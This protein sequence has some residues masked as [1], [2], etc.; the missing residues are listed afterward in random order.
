MTLRPTTR[1]GL[2]ALGLGLTA[3]GIAALPLAATT[4]AGA[5]GASFSF[6]FIG[7][8]P[9]KAVQQGQMPALTADVNADPDVAFVAHS[10]DFKG[11][12]DSCSD[13]N[14][15][16]T[17][18]LFSAF[19]TPFWYTIGDND[20]T[21]C[22]RANNGGFHPLERLAKVRSLYF[23]TPTQTTDF[24]VP[25]HP[26]LAVHPQ[27]AVPGSDNATYVDNNWFQKDC[28][29]FGSVH[30][31]TSNNGLPNKLV[32]NGS[33]DTTDLA[34]Y[35]Y[36]A[37]PAITIAPPLSGY[38]EA[39]SFPAETDA[40]KQEALA[41]IAADV[42]W[43]DAIFDAAIAN[44]SE[45]VFI[46]TQAEP[47]VQATPDNDKTFGD[48]FRAIRDR[49]FARADAFGKPVILAHGDQHVY[50]VTPNY[51]GHP[52]ITRYEN[53]GSNTG[54]VEATTKW[55]KVTASCGTPGVFTQEARTVG[56]A[57]VPVVPEGPLTLGIAAAGGI[58]VAGIVLV[59]ATRR[60]PAVA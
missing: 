2:R 18:N 60:R 36:T 17:K 56:V 3:A 10:G 42:R 27:S 47:L 16:T 20:W 14:V 44:G 32:Y 33:G 8:V 34:N 19:A 9:Y 43:V 29:T 11:G 22:H 55:V 45:G 57:P 4:P 48:E 46:L 25:G 59:R 35:T 15:T 39:A 23:S 54:G 5:T 6:A 53:F 12:S 31:V 41:R 7:D 13:A 1:R 51:L 52:N 40:R 28:V 50:T 38:D 30:S 58:A 49:I 26:T 24:G 21:D 37:T